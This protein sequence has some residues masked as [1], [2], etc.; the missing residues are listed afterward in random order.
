[1]SQIGVIDDAPPRASIEELEHSD[2]DGMHQFASQSG[3]VCRCV[4]TFELKIISL[5]EKVAWSRLVKQIM[6]RLLIRN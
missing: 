4:K 2:Q 1:V 5:Q 6:T 3:I